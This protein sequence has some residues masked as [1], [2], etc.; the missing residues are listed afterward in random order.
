VILTKSEKSR[1]QS[2]ILMLMKNQDTYDIF[3][4][5]AGPVYTRTGRWNITNHYMEIVFPPWRPHWSGEPGGHLDSSDPG[6]IES[7]W[8]SIWQF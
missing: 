2:W 6:S 8:L 1:I 4:V 7:R 3:H 5:R